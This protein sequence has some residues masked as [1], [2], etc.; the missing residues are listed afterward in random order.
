MIGPARDIPV[1]LNFHDF[2]TKLI[3]KNDI[4]IFRP[5]YLFGYVHY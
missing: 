3:Y 1:F 2:I 5:I 4:K